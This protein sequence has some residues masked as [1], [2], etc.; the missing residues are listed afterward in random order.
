MIG[1]TA[2]VR[3]ASSSTPAGVHE[4]EWGLRSGGVASLNHRL[5]ARNPP[6]SV[7]RAPDL[8]VMRSPNA[9]EPF[10]S[11]RATSNVEWGRDERKRVRGEGAAS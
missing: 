8:W 9:G 10:D 6:G 2:F 7:R 4:D 3:I 5:I 11:L 1:R